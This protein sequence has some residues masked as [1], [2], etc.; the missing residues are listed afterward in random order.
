MKCL[1][2]KNES[3][4]SKSVEHIIPQ[5]LGNTQLILPKGFVCDKCNN[6]FS[7]K[8]EQPFFDMEEI[9]KLRFYQKIPN[10]EGKVPSINAV[11]NEKR[12]NIERLFIKES[13]PNC[14][15]FVGVTGPIE[16]GIVLTPSYN[17]GILLKP[18]R[19]ISRFI[20]K[21]A[22]E[23]FALKFIDD[24]S[25]IEYI[26][27]NKQ[28]DDMRNY[29]RF[30]SGDIWPYKVRRI[31]DVDA[32]H[33]FESNSP[34][35]IVHESDFLMIQEKTHFDDAGDEICDAYIYFVV[36]LWGLEFVINLVDRSENSLHKYN[37]W[38]NSHNDISF[39]HY[40]KNNTSTFYKG[41]KNE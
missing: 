30:N 1:F 5:T 37:Q 36:A 19:V 35:Q 21:I 28:L 3:D 15:D 22:F 11:L 23:S 40:G 25:W 7:R 29:V 38:L 20:A 16:E 6:Y 9:K 10:K 32:T 31:Y 26:L 18:S 14:M 12:I 27:N 4:D 8:I 24:S 13:F 39:L 33:F 2:C 17:D 34:F 41:D